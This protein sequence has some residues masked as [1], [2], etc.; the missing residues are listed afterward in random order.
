MSQQESTPEIT[1]VQYPGLTRG[2][3]ISPF[4]GKVHMT[5]HAKGLTYRTRNLSTPMQV[6]R[7][8]PRGRVPVL[9]IDGETFVDSTDIVTELDRRFPDPR[10]QPRD[11]A[12]WAPVKIL[13]DWADEVLYFYDVYLRFC[14]PENFARMKK[15]LLSKLAI[16]ARWIAPVIAVREARARTRGQGVGLK[17][18]GVV[19]REFDECLDALVVLLG[20]GAF[21]AGPKLT[22]ADIAICAV[23]DQLRLAILTPDAAEAIAK[24][25]EILDWMARVHAV[26]PNAAE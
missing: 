10:L 5:L 23:L 26:A 14:V 4:C 7:F 16:P 13:E 19:R 3:T 1:L 6:K 18:A 8:N 9:I 24:H 12:E 2:K 17:D 22:R 25:P 11:P 21:V 20:S 15:H